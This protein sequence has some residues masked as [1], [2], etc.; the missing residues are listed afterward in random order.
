MSG[1]K[2]KNWGGR[3]ELG[4]GSGRTK[5]GERLQ[6]YKKELACGTWQK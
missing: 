1:K 4:P 6:V 5:G 2:D 3:K